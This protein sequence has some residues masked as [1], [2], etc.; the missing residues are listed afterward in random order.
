MLAAQ[1]ATA[2]TAPVNAALPSSV[3]DDDIGEDGLKLIPKVKPDLVIMDVRMGGITG[4]LFQQFAVT[5][6]VATASSPVIPWQVN[7]KV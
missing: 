6:S 2:Q 5:I 7:V 3:S 4:I 1:G